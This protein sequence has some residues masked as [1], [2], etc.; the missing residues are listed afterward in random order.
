[1][2]I[3]TDTILFNNYWEEYVLYGGMPFVVQIEPFKEKSKREALSN[4]LTIP[5]KKVKDAIVPRYDEF[6]ISKSSKQR[7]VIRPYLA[8]TLL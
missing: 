3:Y 6:C 1:M 2:G 7:Y 5:L 4:K 8:V